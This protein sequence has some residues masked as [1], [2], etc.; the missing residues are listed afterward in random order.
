M[1]MASSPVSPREF[2]GD[3]SV[4]AESTPLGGDLQ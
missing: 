4:V 2:L 3:D 1:E